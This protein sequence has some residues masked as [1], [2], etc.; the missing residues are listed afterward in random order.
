MLRGVSLHLGL[1]VLGLMFF[2]LI[3]LHSRI[4]RLHLDGGKNTREGVDVVVGPV[5]Q[6][7]DEA[8]RFAFGAIAVRVDE[9]GIAST[10]L[11]E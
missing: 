10:G 6:D 9:V 8:F 7:W 1:L 5:L 11:M 2:G 4:L 3:A